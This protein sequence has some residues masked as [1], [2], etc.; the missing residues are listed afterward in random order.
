MCWCD[1]PNERPTSNE[2]LKYT[3]SYEFSHLLDV[4]VLEDYEHPPLVL[5][6]LNQ[7]ISILNQYSINILCYLKE[8]IDSIEMDQNDDLGKQINF[9]N[10]T[11]SMSLVEE[12]IEEEEEDVIDLWVVR[13]SVDEGASQF[14]IL[15]YENKLNCTNRK[16]VN[17]CC[18]EI[19][20][21]CVYNKNQVWCVDANKCIYIYCCKTYRK[22]NQYL[23]DIKSLSNIIAMFAIENAYRLLL[24]SSNGM[25]VLINAESAHNLSLR[26]NDLNFENCL[27]SELEYYI[28][29]ISIQITT[30]I[31]IPTR[32]DKSF[33]LW[34]GSSDSEIFCFSLKSMKI[35]GSY[36][37]S[38]SYH[39]L[40]N[41]VL[42]PSTSSMRNSVLANENKESN[43]TILR[44]TPNDTFFLW[45]YINPG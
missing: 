8:I 19:E 17:V 12:E 26:N 25:I 31:L 34:M 35:T 37:H 5:A 7:G 43:V 38:T 20:S 33:D 41:S 11:Q 45:S 28:N 1:D 39:Y 24:C 6:C 2:I 23:L 22:I 9:E 40:A 21:L 3:E 4:T 42:Q 14:E 27:D 32:F 29:D 44:T 30:A 15:T 36:L 18:D 13:N 16:L 10:E